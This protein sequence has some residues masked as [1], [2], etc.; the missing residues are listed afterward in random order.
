MVTVEKERASWQQPEDSSFA[1]W[2]AGRVAR[3]QTRRYDW[4]ALKFQADYDPRYRRAQMR[5]VGT[6]GTGVASD[7]NTVPAGAFTFSTMVVPAGHIGPSHI[8]VD[9]EEIFFVLR[10]KM[11]VVCERDGERWEAELGERD[12]ISVPPGVYRSETNIGEEDALMCVML[13]SPRPVTPT[14]PPD[15]PLSRI[16]RQ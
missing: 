9:V 12:L 2:L 13:G 6:G 15:S 1:D 11:Q 5:Y 4:D 10:G 14:Y 7:S 8:H 3:L 16:K